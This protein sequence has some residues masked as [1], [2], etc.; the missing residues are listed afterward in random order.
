MGIKLD[1]KTKAV[2]AV[3]LSSIVGGATASATKI[4][5]VNIPPFSFSFLRFLLASIFILPFFLSNKPKLDKNLYKVL[6][7]TLLAVLNVGLFVFGIRLTTAS[8]SGLLYSAT[9]IF[10]VI[11]SYFFLKEKQSL[12]RLFFVM[13]GLFGT[14]L[15]VFSPAI[16]KQS[17][18]K[19]NLLGNIVIF[20]AVIIWSLYLV[21]SK[22][23]QKTYSPIVM[24]SLFIFL[25][26]VLF[27]VLSL[28]EIRT[29][30]GWWRQINL[31]AV[32]AIVYVSLF[33]TLIFYLLSQYAVKYGTPVIAS[34]AFYL[35]PIMT[36]FWAFILLG[37]KLTSTLVVGTFIVFISVILINY[38]ST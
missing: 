37:E 33:S 34:L 26:S 20:I 9:V 25:S 2:L 29:N 19:G 31:S 16:E 21:F 10:S 1:Q 36:Y 18:F 28:I 6:L 24:T 30:F 38:F 5:L 15:A 11:F 17:I 7:V 12:K 27:F 35:S 14:S 3:L 32:L 4:G 22:K 8:I 13:I 23:M